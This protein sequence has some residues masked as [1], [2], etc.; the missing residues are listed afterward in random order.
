[1]NTNLKPTDQFTFV[2]TIAP[3]SQGPGTITS[4]WISAADYVAFR[5]KV[6][7]GV[8]GSSATVDA[9]LQQA[10]DNSGAGA[11]DIA[12]SAI[13]QLTKT[14]TDD[15]KVAQINLRSDRLDIN[16]GYKYFRVSLTVAAAASLV[17]ADVDGVGAYTSPGTPAAIVDEVVTV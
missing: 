11:K 3:I 13:T 15:G 16:A 10:T 5:V 6:G 8:L 4:G 2:A 7:V 14:G 9:K 1:M 17:N 12:G